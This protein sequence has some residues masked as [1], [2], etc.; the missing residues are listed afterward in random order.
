[1]YF[2]IGT[3]SS[4]RCIID[5]AFRSQICTTA[6]LQSCRPSLSWPRTLGFISFQVVISSGHD[7][8]LALA[9]V[10]DLT[11]DIPAKKATR[12]GRDSLPLPTHKL[13]TI[14]ITEVP[15][16]LQPFILSYMLLSTPVGGPDVLLLRC[17]LHQ[18]QLTIYFGNSHWW[19]ELHSVLG[20]GRCKGC[21]KANVHLMLIPYA[22]GKRWILSMSYSDVSCPPPFH[23]TACLCPRLPT[24]SNKYAQPRCTSH[25]LALW[26][27]LVTNTFVLE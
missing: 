14:Q 4:R 6:I 2:A 22:T 24:Y 17:W 3:W 26:M 25:H 16:N 18:R 27:V 21:C 1:M 19:V 5:F 12:V 20:V 15:L 23:L 7:I 8:D 10:Y 11:D 9:A 13:T